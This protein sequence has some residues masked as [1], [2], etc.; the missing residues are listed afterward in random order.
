VIERID[1]IEPNPVQKEHFSAQIARVWSRLH[2]VVRHILAD[3][4]PSEEYGVAGLWPNLNRLVLRHIP[5]SQKIRQLLAECMP[6]SPGRSYDSVNKTGATSMASLEA[7]L[8]A[9]RAWGFDQVF[10]LVDGVDAY[11]RE[12]KNMMELIAPLLGNLSYWQKQ[13][14][15]FYFFL[16]DELRPVIDRDFGRAL[17]KLPFPPFKYRIHWNKNELI[18][19]LHKRLRAAGSRV[20]GFNALAA[21]ELGNKLEDFLIQAAENSPR[22]LLR[23]V[24]SLID[25]HAEESADQPLF[26]V[27]DWHLMHKRWSYGRPIP[28]DIVFPGLTNLGTLI[29][30]I[31]GSKIF[32]IPGHFFGEG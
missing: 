31:F 25:V 4:L 5:P 1:S 29:L 19:L 22:Q 7:G 12:I 11:E 30:P 20:P 2:R 17:K 9:A 26:T 18:R 8:A 24:S 13:N 23:V 3:D 6:R 28:P 15:F 14:L 21:E 16:T 32:F 10:V 27:R